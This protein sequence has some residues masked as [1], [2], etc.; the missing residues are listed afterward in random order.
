MRRI[1]D[2]HMWW[3]GKTFLEQEIFGRPGYE[4]LTFPLA[5]GLTILRKKSE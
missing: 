3:L 2:Q 4:T 5:Q 1:G